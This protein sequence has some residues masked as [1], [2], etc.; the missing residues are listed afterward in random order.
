MEV[1]HPL[2]QQALDLWCLRCPHSGHVGASL[3]CVIPNVQTEHQC[4]DGADNNEPSVDFQP[5]AVGGEDQSGDGDEKR[6][7]DQDGIGD[8]GYRL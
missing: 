6:D 3:Q 5:C 2:L 8:T 7:E 1:A 4:K